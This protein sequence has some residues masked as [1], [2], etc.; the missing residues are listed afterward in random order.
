MMEISGPCHTEITL[1]PPELMKW[2]IMLNQI[3]ETESTEIFIKIVESTIPGSEALL[4]AYV[5]YH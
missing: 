4:L 1:F 5:R 3:I 2:G